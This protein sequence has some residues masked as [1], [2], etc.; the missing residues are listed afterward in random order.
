MTPAQAKMTPEEVVERGKSLYQSRLRS[1]LI[2]GNIGKCLVID[3][4][5]GAYE[6]GNTPLETTK[7]AR[8]KYP[9]ARLY[10]MRI[11]YAA[12]ASFGAALESEL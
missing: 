2:T 12:I 5:T 11:G 6:I 7:R 9:E 8:A 1:K 3:V 10:G 4:M